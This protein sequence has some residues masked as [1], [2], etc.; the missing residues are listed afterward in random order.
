MARNQNHTNVRNLTNDEGKI[1]ENITSNLRVHVAKHKRHASSC[2]NCNFETKTEGNLTDHVA[3]QRA[4]KLLM[5]RVKNKYE[6]LTD[7]YKCRV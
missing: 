5:K 4:K 1:S 3:K 7:A 2:N 6:V